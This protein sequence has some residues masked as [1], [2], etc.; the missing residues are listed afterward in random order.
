MRNGHRGGFPSPISFVGATWRLVPSWVGLDGEWGGVRLGKGLVFWGCQLTSGDT[1]LEQSQV[2]FVASSCREPVGID[3]GA[4]AAFSAAV[5]ELGDRR[6]DIVVMDADNGRQ[7]TVAAAV[8]A[9]RAAEVS[10]ERAL[11]HRR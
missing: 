10:R 7:G 9:R 5:A 8:P 3:E 2:I 6:H 1:S 4:H 11:A